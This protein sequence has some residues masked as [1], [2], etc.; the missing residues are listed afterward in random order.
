MDKLQQK[1]SE[2]RK[3]KGEKIH[4]RLCDKFWLRQFSEFIVFTKAYMI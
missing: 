1:T 2:M 3:N 4:E